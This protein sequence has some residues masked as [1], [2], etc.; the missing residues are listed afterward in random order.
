MKLSE[1]LLKKIGSATKEVV[2][3]TI[4]KI[5]DY[6]AQDLF[7]LNYY[8]YPEVFLKGI[9]EHESYNDWREKVPA[10]PAIITKEAFDT[11]QEEK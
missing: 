6:Q 10:H 8:N 7:C 9:E 11:V 3:N 2:I 1:A 5:Y 4:Y